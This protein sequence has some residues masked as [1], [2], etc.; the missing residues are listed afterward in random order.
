M[1]RAIV[2]VDR[3]E[4]ELDAGLLADQPVRACADRLLHE[5]GLA[6]PF[7]VLLRYHPPGTANIAGA[8]QDREVE[9]RFLE[10][11]LD[12]A[13]VDEI[14]TVQPFFAH[15]RPRAVV[16]LEAPFHVLRR[17]RCAVM[18]L[19]ARPQPE[20]GALGVLGELVFVGE[21]EVVVSHLAE[22]F[23]QCIVQREG[24][25]VRT[26]RA[27]VLLRVDPASGDVGVPGQGHLS[28]GRDVRLGPQAAN[29][30]RGQRCRRQRRRTQDRPTGKRQMAHSVLPHAL[31][32]A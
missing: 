25:I 13:V 28:P 11:E 29:K 20:S 5:S 32:E 16:I 4:L 26:R 22:I 7:V 21:R 9:E 19:D 2:A 8:E 17:D 6:D 31:I 23:D 30:R 1:D 3:F 14:D 15:R 27:V 18:E 24:E 12:G 10:M